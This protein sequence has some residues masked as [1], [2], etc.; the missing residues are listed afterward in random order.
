MLH[1]QALNLLWVVNV[2]AYAEFFQ[3]AI[4]NTDFNISGQEVLSLYPQ[5]PQ[6]L[7]MFY[8]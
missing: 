3:K 2:L 8:N 6:K 1:L 4:L 5:V 7:A